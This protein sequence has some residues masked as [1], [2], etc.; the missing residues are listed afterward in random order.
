MTICKHSNIPKR[1]L[2]CKEVKTTQNGI[3]GSL[4]NRISS[5]KSLVILYL[6]NQKCKWRSL[7]M[8]PYIKDTPSHW[9]VSKRA[10]LFGVAH[11]F[12]FGAYMQS[13]VI[14]KHWPWKITF[15]FNLI[16]L[17]WLIMQQIQRIVLALLVSNKN[18][19]TKINRNL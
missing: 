3:C 18:F 6:S 13:C 16:C 19:P 9:H 1:Q 15:C 12:S 4:A 8:I 17:V 10:Q 2:Y 7:L 5:A 11:K 14:Y